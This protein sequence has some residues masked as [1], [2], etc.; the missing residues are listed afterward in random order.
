MAYLSY[1]QKCER[2][3]T[4]KSHE[5][6][7][8]YGFSTGT[9]ALNLPILETRNEALWSKIL[10]ALALNARKREQLVEKQKTTSNSSGLLIDSAMSGSANDW[11]R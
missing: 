6:R 9:K 2:H 5:N 1:S 3:R 8:T 11:L 4:T 7:V 10:H